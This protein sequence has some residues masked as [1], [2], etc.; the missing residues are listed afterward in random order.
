MSI[1]G[2]ISELFYIKWSV[3]QYYYNS[4]TQEDRQKDSTKL[5]RLKYFWLIL[6]KH[7]VQVLIIF[8]QKKRFSIIKS[9]VLNL[10]QN[11]KTF[12]LWTVELGNGGSF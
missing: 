5:D 3:E 10:Q 11:N 2:Y 1:P 6:I 12:D 4:Y 7:R 8:I 9:L